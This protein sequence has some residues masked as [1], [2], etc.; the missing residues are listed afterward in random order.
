[1]RAR[2]RTAAILAAA[3]A[4]SA[5]LAMFAS[6]ASAGPPSGRIPPGT[7]FG[8]VPCGPPATPEVVALTYL[9]GNA[10]AWTLSNGKMM[11]GGHFQIEVTNNQTGTSVVITGDGVGKTV[12]QADGTSTLHADGMALWSFFPGDVGPGDQSTG[13]LFLFKGTQTATISASGATTAFNYSGKI[14]EDV[15]A[16]VS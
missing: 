6:V 15:C 16:A 10:S 13:R 2:F 7:S 4:G 8:S 14:V 5:V 9:G 3:V 11:S 1:M 12:S